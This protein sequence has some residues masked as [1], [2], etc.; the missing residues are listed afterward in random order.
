M[1][2]VLMFA[3]AL[4]ISVSFVATG[5]AQDKA[6]APEKPAAAA[7]EKAKAPEKPAAVAPEKAAA[8]EKVAAPEK[9]AKPKAKPRV[10]F[11]GMVTM[12]D[13]AAKELAVKGKKD[14]VTFD[15]T[16]AKFK[17]YKKAEEIQAGDKVLVKYVKDGVKVEKI[18]GKKAEKAAKAA[19]ADKPAKAKK[20]SFKDV[21]K[22]GDGKVTIEEL[23]VVF[24]NV[25]PEQFKALDKNGDGALD[26][27]EFKAV[28]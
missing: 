10:G 3:L 5:F 6:K 7:P 21:D 25:T 17:G 2:K 28:K 16:N 27:K 19:K 22:N 4:L 15:L 26:E 23:I 8:P 11:V 13:L 1:K 20:A 12:V 18:A 14:A 24:V 9:P